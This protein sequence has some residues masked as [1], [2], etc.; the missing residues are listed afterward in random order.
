MFINKTAI[1][2]MFKYLQTLTYIMKIYRFIVFS[3]FTE[4][5]LYRDGV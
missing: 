4:C 3:I 5:V 2:K 1:Y